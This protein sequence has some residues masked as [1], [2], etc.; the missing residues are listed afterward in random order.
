[1]YCIKAFWYTKT[2]LKIYEIQDTDSD[3]NLKKYQLISPNQFLV[4]IILF[5]VYMWVK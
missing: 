5:C 3:C 2:V 4:Y 1:M